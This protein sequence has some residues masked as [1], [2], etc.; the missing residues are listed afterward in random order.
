MEGLFAK[1]GAFLNMTEELPFEEFSAY[2]GALTGY[3]QAEYQNLDE[4]ALLKAQS[5]CGIVA[6]NA[7]ARAAYKD[8][9][10]KKFQK[11]A[12]KASFWEDAIKNRLI[13]GG[14]SLDEIEE[15]TAALWQEDKP[16]EE[17][18]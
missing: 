4:A 6:S 7:Q 8:G 11:M 9:N 16:Q 14:L 10:R 13:K 12:E 3:L 1:M 17:Q 15:K 5:L 18:A 2:Y